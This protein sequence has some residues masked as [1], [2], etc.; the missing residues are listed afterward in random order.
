MWGFIVYH[1]I[2]EILFIGLSVAAIVFFFKIRSDIDTLRD[3]KVKTT[4]ALE[5]TNYYTILEKEMA[6]DEINKYEEFFRKYKLE[7][8]QTFSKSEEISDYFNNIYRLSLAIIILLIIFI[9]S[10]FFSSICLCLN[11][12]DEEVFLLNF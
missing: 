8:G 2:R 1:S 4:F 6:N 7:E 3:L 9:L 5:N 11:E 12:P 10:S